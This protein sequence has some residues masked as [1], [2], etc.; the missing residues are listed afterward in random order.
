MGLDRSKWKATGA[1]NIRSLVKI[2]TTLMATIMLNGFNS[3][4]FNGLRTWKY[5]LPLVD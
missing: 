4:I 5:R 1:L 2:D 3:L